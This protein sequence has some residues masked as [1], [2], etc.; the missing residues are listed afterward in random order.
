MREEDLLTK[1]E[2]Q[3]LEAQANLRRLE[4]EEQQQGAVAGAAHVQDKREVLSYMPLEFVDVWL[5]H[6]EARLHASAEQ[7]IAEVLEKVSDKLAAWAT[8]QLREIEAER[9]RLQSH[10]DSMQAASSASSRVDLVDGGVVGPVGIVRRTVPSDSVPAEGLP[11]QIDYNGH[12]IDLK[13]SDVPLPGRPVL[14]W[15]GQVGYEQLADRLSR[16]S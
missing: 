3:L 10:G 14:N 16:L 7:W 6:A 8:Q 13:S 5:R 1:T 12:R 15:R 2:Q 11:Y 9:A 4:E